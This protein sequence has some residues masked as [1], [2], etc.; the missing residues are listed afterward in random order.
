[1]VAL[2]CGLLCEASQ[3]PCKRCE[4]VQSVEPAGQMFVLSI[5]RWRIFKIWAG[6]SKPASKLIDEWAQYVSYTVNI[7]ADN[8]HPGFS[9]AL[10]DKFT[11]RGSRALFTF[12]FHST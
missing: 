6:G 11:F 2:W 7:R 10:I 3:T 12:Q 1:M 9:K 4:G 8:R 5:L